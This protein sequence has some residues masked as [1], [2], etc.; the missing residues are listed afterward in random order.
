LREE[1]FVFLSLHRA[2]GKS[3]LFHNWT[4][5]GT[6]WYYQVTTVFA[7]MCLPAYWYLVPG[8]GTQYSVKEKTFSPFFA[9]SEIIV[10]PYIS[11]NL[12]RA[13]NYQLSALKC[14]HATYTELREEYFDFLSPNKPS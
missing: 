10:E 12:P 14:K 1:Y 4:V 5:P 2:L 9:M 7:G 3:P 8:P 11:V 6:C 13:E